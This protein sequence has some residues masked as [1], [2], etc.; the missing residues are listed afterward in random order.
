MPLHPKT[1]L[2]L[3]SFKSRLDC[4]FLVPAYPG[5]PGKEAFKR[6]TA[7]PHCMHRDAAFC[8]KC[9]VVCVYV[10]WS[11]QWAVLSQPRC[12][13]CCRL[14]GARGTYIWWGLDPVPEVTFSRTLSVL[15]THTHT[16]PFK[17]RWSG[18]TRVGR[19]QKKFTHSHPSW[20]SDILY[21]L[22]PFTTI[23]SNLCVQFKCL[24]VL[25]D[26]LSPGPLWSFSW[27]WT[28]YFI[29]HAFLSVLHGVECWVGLCITVAIVINSRCDLTLLT[30]D[31]CNVWWW[32]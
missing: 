11:R 19:Y 13:I 9:S 15:H 7:M 5:C 23:H 12:R 24:T 32:W 8:Y 27:S 31:C 21:Q 30:Q 25:I 20:S 6:V 17:S 2:S 10:C 3:A 29:L 26:H 22:P 4:T 1:Q 28:L 16:Q 14:V 18:T